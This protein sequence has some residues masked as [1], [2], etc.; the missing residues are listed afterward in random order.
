ME[1]GNGKYIAAI[2]L[3][4]IAIVVVVVVGLT[5]SESAPATS[6]VPG[7][8][9]V[10]S[11]TKVPADMVPTAITGFDQASKDLQFKSTFA[12]EELAAAVSFKPSTGSKYENKV[13]SLTVYAHQFKD[14]KSAAALASRL[15]TSG[16]PFERD[17]S[18]VKVKLIEKADT[19]EFIQYI[20]KDRI[21]AY[22]FV[23]T[24]AKASFLDRPTIQDAV[25]L[26]FSMVKF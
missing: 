15:A 10:V 19:G 17:V 20:Q 1:G 22:A 14:A 5:Q 6:T 7:A 3:I 23:K 9:P 12:G 25:I 8:L 13:E 4:I 18:G 11:A 21:V 24:S 2:F 26:G 16:T